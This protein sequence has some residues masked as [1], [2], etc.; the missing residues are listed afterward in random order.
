MRT[1]R[2][3]PRMP[4]FSSTARFIFPIIWEKVFTVII[5]LVS[6]A[7]IGGISSSALAAVGI[8]NTMITTLSAG[9][10][11]IVVVG[12]SVLVARSTGARDVNETSRTVEQSTLLA[13][14]MGTVVGLAVFFCSRWI[15]QFL[16]PTAEAALFQEAVQY[17]R[18]MA[19]S[20]PFI[21]V[22]D[23]LSGVFRSAGQSRVPMVAAVLL[24]LVQ[25]FLAWLLIRVLKLDML[26]AGLSYIG[27]RVFGAVFIGILI[28]RAL[29]AVHLIAQNFFRPDGV[30]LRRILR[31][32]MP[33]ALEQVS[34][35]AAYL[36]ANSIIVGLGTQAASTY[37]VVSTINSFCTIPQAIGGPIGVTLIGQALGAKEVSG[38]RHKSLVLLAVIMGTQLL[39]GF[40]AAVGGRGFSGIYSTDPAVISQ[41]VTL[42]WAMFIINIFAT[43][44][45]VIDPILRTGGDTRFV[46]IYT[47]VCVWIV[48]LGLTL[49]F[50]SHMH[51][52]LF[53]VYLANGIALAL[54]AIIGLL[55]FASNKWIHAKI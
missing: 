15:M 51:M 23:M 2:L 53:G 49:L 36:I 3:S 32:G 5:G 31:I 30:I 29:P 46:M 11:G 22:L 12:S 1:T 9:C 34:V 26:G 6:S 54:R 38:A 44:I 7:L 16:M 55:R 41:S 18:L 17:T 48:R 8:V 10:S 33:S 19:I 20:F 27:C 37:Q 40:T 52:G 45:N 43:S 25:I 24:N 50:C 13:V 39:F 28:F 4:R 42:L 47:V 35:Q 21:L 14:V